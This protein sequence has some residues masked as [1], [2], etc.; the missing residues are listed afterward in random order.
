VLCRPGASAP[1][2]AI[3]IISGTSGTEGFQNWEVPW[4]RRLQ[5]AGYVALIVDS[6][7]ARHLTFAEHWRLGPAARAQDALDAGSF[8]AKQP[9]VRRGKIGVIGR[10]GGG[11]AVLGAIVERADRARSLPFK[12]AVA[13]YGYCPGP[14]RRLEGR[15]VTRA[16]Q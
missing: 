6:F 11:T 4:A 16:L 8:L 13:D 15:D 1:A 3:A 2:P 14:L 10:S 5:S 12:M 7:T 9:F